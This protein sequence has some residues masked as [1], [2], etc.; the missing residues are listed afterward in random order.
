MELRT[1]PC[2][3]ERRLAS[4]GVPWVAVLHEVVIFSVPH[5]RSDL[6]MSERVM[7]ALK[8]PLFCFK[9]LTLSLVQVDYNIGDHAVP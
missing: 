7:M 1:P 9:V 2:Q 3:S 8:L 5:R 4:W 6:A